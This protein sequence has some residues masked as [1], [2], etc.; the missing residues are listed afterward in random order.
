MHEM[1]LVSNTR[2]V[3]LFHLKFS[4]STAIITCGHGCDLARDLIEH[5]GQYDPQYRRTI[6]LT[7]VINKPYF[8]RMLFLAAVHVNVSLE[9]SHLFSDMQS[10]ITW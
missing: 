4:V 9:A 1:S 3:Q 8:G 5:C 6:A 7:H 10:I 2:V